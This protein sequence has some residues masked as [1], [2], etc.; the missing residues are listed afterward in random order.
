MVG[1][2]DYMNKYLDRRMKYLIDDWDL[3]TENDISD[4]DARLQAVESDTRELADFERGAE[5]KLDEM[6]ARLK[7]LREAKK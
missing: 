4:F 7:K 3:A 2:D 1:T 6:A 5:E